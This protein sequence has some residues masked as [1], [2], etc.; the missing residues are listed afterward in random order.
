[1]CALIVTLGSSTLTIGEKEIIK[2]DMAREVQFKP[3]RHRRDLGQL[4]SSTSIELDTGKTFGSRSVVLR[5]HKSLDN[6]KMNELPKR[7]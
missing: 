3:H 6:M 4:S 2:Y 5:H 1:M 7:N